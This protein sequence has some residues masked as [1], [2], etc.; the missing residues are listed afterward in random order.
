[1]GRK[2]RPYLFYDSA[3]SV[4]SQCLMRVEAKILIQ[5]ERVIME[6]WCPQ[7]GRQRVLIADDAEYYR[8]AREKFIKAPE[9]PQRFNT[10]MRW[11]CPYDCGLCPD[12][13]QHSCLSIIEINDHC[14]LNCPICYAESGPKRTEEKSLDEI[15]AMFK[16]IC[17]NEGEPDVVQISGGEPTLHPAFFSIMDMAKRFPIKHLML[18]TNGLRIATQPEFTARLASY[19]PNFEIYL[20]FDSLREENLQRLRGAKLLDTRMRAIEQLNRHNLSTTLVVTLMKGVNDN[21]VGEIIDFALQQECVRGVTLQ[22][23]QVAGRVEGYDPAKNRL[24]LTEVRRAIFEQSNCF[25]KQDIVPVPCNPDCLAMA[26]ALKLNGETTPLTGLINPDWLLEG[27]ENT[28][29]FEHQPELKQRL[30]NLFSTSHS[31]QSSSTALSELLCCLPKIEKLNGLDY[32]NVFR[33]LI[34]QFLDIHSF[35]VRVAKKSCVHFAQPNGEIIPF[36]TYNLFYRGDLREQLE[37]NRGRFAG[38]YQETI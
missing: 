14:N 38:L 32:T 2:I 37:I 5:G 27:P 25:N 11:G 4:C 8:L 24:T 21:E 22:P 15:E 34:M 26:Y 17:K 23:V 33:V 18:N 7:H 6:K 19:A 1:M 30:G 9:I 13:M 31:P 20:Q 29:V 3:T 16:A 12:H 35:D 28:I 36:D 10:P